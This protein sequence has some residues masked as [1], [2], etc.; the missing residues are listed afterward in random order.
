MFIIPSGVFSDI[1]SV[2]YEY[3]GVNSLTVVAPLIRQLRD[4]TLN[5]LFTCI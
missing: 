4:V 3:Y 1:S 2:S 5:I